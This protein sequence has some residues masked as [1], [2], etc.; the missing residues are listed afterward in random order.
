MPNKGGSRLQF[1]EAELDGGHL[2]EHDPAKESADRAAQRKDAPPKDPKKLQQRI[3]KKSGADG[4]KKGN[5]ASEKK[6]TTRGQLQFE[7]EIDRTLD[8]YERPENACAE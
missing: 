5:S 3:I 2:K 8:D 1:T 6:T 4:K 7:E